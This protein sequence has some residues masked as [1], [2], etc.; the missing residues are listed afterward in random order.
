MNVN[1][2]RKLDKWLGVP[3]CA[4]LTLARKLAD[5][6]GAGN[7]ELPHR[8]VFVKLAEQGATVLADPALRKAVEMVG[9]EN[10]VFLVFQ[11]NRFILDV[12]DVIPKEN[13]IAIST[14]GLLQVIRDALRGI[15]RMRRERID[16][17]I[18][19]EFF[20]RS[21]AA[22]SYLSGAAHRVGFHAFAGEASY[23]GD[24]MTHRL[25]FNAY[26][27]V[28]QIFQM[29]VEA[30]NTPTAILPAFD[31]TP[32]EA[33][34]QLP[35]F[36]PQ[37][38]EIAKVKKVLC[39]TLKKEELPPL[40]LLNANC[41]DLLPLRRWPTERYV[42][43]THRLLEKY[44]EIGIA[45]TGAPSEAP[46]A[47]NLV[48]QVGSER[49]VCMAGRTTLREL[50]VLY[51]LAEVLVTND[52]GPAHFAT[53]TPIDVITMFGPETPAAFGARTPRSHILWSG[54]VCSPCVNA[55]NDRQSSCIDNI[56]MQRISVDQVFEKVCKVYEQRRKPINKGNCEAATTCK[57]EST[58]HTV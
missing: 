21:S 52:S 27:H 43:L 23:R 38:E 10:V 15:R 16:A 44:K 40:F 49:C 39:D 28:S 6:F 5:R 25:S 46:G 4:V 31:L 20:A 50:L 24:L 2:M 51:C 57:N 37:T 33:D 32:P 30:L 14:K 58:R 53:L 42:E 54:I 41:S 7:N 35:S 11:E 26:L 13:V 19:F 9:R 48:K 8:I 3:A 12:L 1:T 36:Q 56:C 22:L 55:Y 34:Q 17:A 47:E 18:D 45:F 29:M